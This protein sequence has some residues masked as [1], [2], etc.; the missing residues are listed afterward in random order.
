MAQ[1]SGV[2]GQRNVIRSQRLIC[3]TRRPVDIEIGRYRAPRAKPLW[4]VELVRDA[5]GFLPIPVAEHALLVENL[6]GANEPAR[7]PAKWRLAA[8]CYDCARNNVIRGY[9]LSVKGRGRGRI[10]IGMDRV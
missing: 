5:G 1:Q 2:H 6:F 7:A 8:C 10:R 4:R 9:D 3:W